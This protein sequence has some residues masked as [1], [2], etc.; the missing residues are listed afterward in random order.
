MGPGYSLEILIPSVRKND[1]YFPY[2]V[3]RN[4]A[5]DMEPAG[6]PVFYFL[7][8]EEADECLDTLLTIN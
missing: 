6:A 4:F 5:T 2:M 7:E 3:K 8:H 1:A